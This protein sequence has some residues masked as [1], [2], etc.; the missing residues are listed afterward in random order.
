IEQAAVGGMMEIEAGNDA[1]QRSKN[2]KIKQLAQVIVNDHTKAN[3]ELDSIARNKG[4]KL[5]SA[6]PIEEQKQISA[7]KELNATSFDHNYLGMMVKD[8]ILTLEKFRLAAKYEDPDI[9]AFAL[10][11]IPVLESHYAKANALD[12]LYIKQKV[13]NGDDLLNID[14][15]SKK[16]H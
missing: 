9:K 10:K 5:P 6:Y 3:Q 8:H 12:S 14:K 2:P 13:N 7:L 11:T 16:P 15:S 4:L 1:L